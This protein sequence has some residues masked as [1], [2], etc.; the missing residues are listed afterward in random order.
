MKITARFP[1][2]SRDV[3]MTRMNTQ[4]STETRDTVVVAGANGFVGKALLPLLLQRF[5]VIA[6]GRS[7]PRASDHPNLEWR[8]CD[9]FSL[10]QTE[11]AVDGARYAFYLVHSMAPSQLTQ[12]GFRDI[13][14]MLADNF[15]RACDDAGVEQIIYLGGLMPLGQGISEHLTSR[16]EVAQVLGARKPAV[17]VIQAGLIIGPGGSSFQIM[18]K[19]VKRLPIMLCP[20]WTSS[21]TQPIALEDVVTILMGCIGKDDFYNEWFDIGGPDRMTYIQMMRETAEVM[22]LKRRIGSIPVFSLWLS[23]GW[24]QLFT[25]ASRQL[26]KPLIE[27][28]RHDMVVQENRLQKILNVQG[29]NFV[30]SLNKALTIERLEPIRKKALKQGPSK[31]PDKQMVCS[32]QRLTLNEPASAQQIASLYADYLRESMGPWLKVDVDDEQCMRFR[33]VGLSKPILVLRYAPHRSEPTR[34]LYY[35]DGGLLADMN[36]MKSANI[37]GRLEFRISGCGNFVLAAIMDF[38][39]KLPWSIYRLTQ[40]PF[41]LRVMNGFSRF[42]GRIKTKQLTGGVAEQV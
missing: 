19:L 23:L 35:I 9:L 34:A 24:I 28:L 10:L 1:H 2:L 42:L 5:K 3:G 27:S 30:D 40:A 16:Y 7:A 22:G 13:D 4:T 29:L 36:K 41:H 11:R 18:Y 31:A 6:L 37:K 12:A 38:A 14:W 15:S 26:I 39:P 32:I 33:V 8:Q 21:Q 20:K 25:G 17:T